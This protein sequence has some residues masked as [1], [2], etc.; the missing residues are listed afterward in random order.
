[1][2]RWLII[3]LL[4][5]GAAAVLYA[6]FSYWPEINCQPEIVQ[7]AKINGV[8]AY[9]FKS[10]DTSLIYGASKTACPL[11]FQ[12]GDSIYLLNSLKGWELNYVAYHELCH[13]QRFQAS[14]KYNYLVDEAICHVAGAAQFY[15]PLEVVE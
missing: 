12:E 5:L 8:Q 13:V 15:K 4:L 3:F 7:A 9:F 2:I 6:A 14:Q 10:N 1:M 11:G